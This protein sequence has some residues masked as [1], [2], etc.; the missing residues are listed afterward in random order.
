MSNRAQL[1]AIGAAVARIAGHGLEDN[2]HAPSSGAWHIWRYGWQTKC[3]RAL[4]A[5]KA[6]SRETVTV[7]QVARRLTPDRDG[8]TWSAGE[9]EA[10]ALCAGWIPDR[11]LGAMLGRSQRAVITARAR[12][13]AQTEAI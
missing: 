1:V 13:K 4:A 6:V 9:L 2:P 5:G 3:R 12:V 8:A 7:R 10:L 11:E